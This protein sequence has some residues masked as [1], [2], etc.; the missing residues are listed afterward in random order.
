MICAVKAPGFGDNRKNNMQDLAILT[1]ATVVSDD[2]GVKLEELKLHDLGSCAKITVTKDDTLVLNGRGDKTA[3][4]D[5]CQSIR[6]QV[7][8]TE[9][10]YEKEKLHERLAKLSGGVAVLKIGGVSEVEV[11]E[12]KDRVTDALNA[13]RAAVE[14]GT[15]PGG[16]M[17]LLYSS[18]ILDN[19]KAPNQDQQFGVKIV[20]KSLSMPAKTIAKNAGLEGEV[21]C[22]KLLDKAHPYSTKGYDAQQEK[23]VEMYE[24]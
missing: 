21:I 20:K 3:V 6:Q 10:S 24:A 4:D 19:V 11:S 2:T 22:G 18:L 1:G 7:E 5:R 15:V 9:S 17:A 16:G 14:E 23:Y 13:T 8:Q 12:K